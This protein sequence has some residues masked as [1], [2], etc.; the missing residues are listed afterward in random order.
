MVYNTHAKKVVDQFYSEH[1]ME[2]MS[3][4][5]TQKPKKEQEG[6]QSVPYEK[7][8]SQKS[9]K[10]KRKQRKRGVEKTV[11][12]IDDVWKLENLYLNGP[13]SFRSAKRLHNLSNL[14]VK[15]FKMYRET[16]PSFNKTVHVA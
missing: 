5:T 11:I 16:K 9:T 14:Q 4:Q 2:T 15:K 8:Q 6:R 12:S 13:A 10:V 3:K 1:E 7:M